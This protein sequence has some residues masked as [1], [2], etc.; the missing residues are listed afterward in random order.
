MLAFPL[1]QELDGEAA[2]RVGLGNLSMKLF[3]LKQLARVIQHGDA[4]KHVLAH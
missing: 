2:A 3:L 4:D 1:S